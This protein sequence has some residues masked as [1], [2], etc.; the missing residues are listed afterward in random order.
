MQ[1]RPTPTPGVTNPP[2]VTLTESAHA[3]LADLSD[4]AA[5]LPGDHDA[6]ARVADKLSEELAE[7]AQMLRSL[8]GRPP[9]MSG[10][11]AALLGALRTAHRAGEDLGETIARGLA[12]LAAELGGSYQVLRN[13]PGSWES[14]LIARLLGGT[15]GQH[16]E[17]LMSTYGP[18]PGAGG[19]L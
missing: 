10:Y 13:R 4:L 8:P 6:N 5:Q 11:N 19:S 12:R 7:L 16:D 15:V 2:E 17:D 3:T 1:K 14:A 18:G 9:E